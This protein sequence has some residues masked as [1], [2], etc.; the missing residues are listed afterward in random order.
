MDSRRPRLSGTEASKDQQAGVGNQEPGR[1]KKLRKGQGERAHWLEMA[2]A[3]G[4]AAGGWCE[5]MDMT[6]IETLVWGR[7][8]QK[9]RG[10]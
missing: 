4:G 5:G 8:R 6:L 1:G 9:I 2:K 3:G 7:N 10:Y